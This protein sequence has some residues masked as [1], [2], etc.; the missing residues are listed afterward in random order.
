MP[1]LKLISYPPANKPHFA[2]H[3][4]I[5]KWLQAYSIKVFEVS[6][7]MS[8]HNS[9]GIAIIIQSQRFRWFCARP[10]H[11]TITAALKLYCK[12]QCF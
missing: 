3:S 12:I 2:A 8:W 9:G 6:A 1:Q 7:T 10:C 11:D 4:T 5:H